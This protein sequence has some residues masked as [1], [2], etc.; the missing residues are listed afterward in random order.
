M[1][2]S[3]IFFLASL[4]I[5]MGVIAAFNAR[6]IRDGSSPWWTTY[7]ISAVTA[8]VWAY[9][10]RANLVPLT[11]ASLFQFFFFHASWYLT[12]IFV[13]GEQLPAR[14]LFGLA[15]AFVGMLIMSA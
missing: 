5:T 7:I 13:I 4:L 12:T 14:K 6:W 15:L 3:K 9:Q 11:M 8:T 10:A 1:P 2:N